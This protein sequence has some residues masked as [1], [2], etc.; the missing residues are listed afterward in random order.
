MVA[1]TLR[2]YS[3]D[4]P[5]IIARK[6]ITEKAIMRSMRYHEAYE[7]YREDEEEGRETILYNDRSTRI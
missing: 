3:H 2:R 1:V 5:D 7:L 6:W 4:A